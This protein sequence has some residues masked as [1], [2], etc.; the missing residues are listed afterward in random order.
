MSWRISHLITEYFNCTCSHTINKV[1]YLESVQSCDAYTTW[2][3]ITNN[4]YCFHIWE[5]S[6]KWIKLCYS[7]RYQR[8]TPGW[9]K[10][11]KNFLVMKAAIGIY[12][13]SIYFMKSSQQYNYSWHS[14]WLFIKTYT[15][16]KSERHWRSNHL[17]GLWTTFMRGWQWWLIK[18]NTFWL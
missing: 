3:I 15:S 11:L 16:Q 10:Y 9:R 2:Y 8:W 13:I 7:T 1:Y 5:Q 4:C 14:C 18:R 6:S 17:Q 12:T